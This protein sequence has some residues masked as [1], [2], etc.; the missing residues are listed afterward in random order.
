MIKK[1]EIQFLAA[2]GY[3]EKFSLWWREALLSSLKQQKGSCHCLPQKYQLRETESR[4]RSLDIL[5]WK[6]LWA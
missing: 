2:F 3:K 4:P 6:K 1:G 5:H